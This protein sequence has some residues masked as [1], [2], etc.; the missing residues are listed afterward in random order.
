MAYL[1]IQPHL[2]LQPYIGAY[3]ISEITEYTLNQAKILPDGC[4]DIIFNIKDEYRTEAGRIL[5]KSE[6]IYLIGT[7]MRFK[8][9]KTIGKAKLLGIRFKPGAFFYFFN[10][11][12]LH[13]FT[14][15]SIELK[16]IA[17]PIIHR[18]DEYT[19]AYL[20]QFLLHKLSPPKYSIIH[21]IKD[22][23]NQNGQ[24]RVGDIAKKHFTTPRQLERHFKN[25]V[26]V[27]P[28]D[29]TSLVRYQFVSSKIK[30]NTSG[31]CLA[32]LAFESGYYDHAHLTKE[33]KRFTGSV[34]S[35]L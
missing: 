27:S 2:A 17:L 28:K 4:V 32:E 34:P 1:E 12:S 13:E 6:A 11:S 35:Q 22:I 19:P 16:N 25:S 23:Q 15:Q 29:F 8:E 31:K 30:N 14:D 5:M 7:M 9:Y 21:I 26:G 20:D 18:I 24:S 3:W 10:L 33:I